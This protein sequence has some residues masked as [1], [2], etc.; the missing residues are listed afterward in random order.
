MNDEINSH[1]FKHKYYKHIPYVL[2]FPAYLIAFFIL[3]NIVNESYPNMFLSHIPLDD[4]IPFCEEF[5]IFYSLWYPLLGAMGIYLLLRDA[6]GFKKYMVYI[7][8]TFFTMIIICAVFP[9]YQ[10]MRPAITGNENVFT[11]I[12][13]R[14][15]TADTCTNVIPSAHVFGSMAVVFACFDCKS[16]KSVWWKIGASV[17]GA[18]IC[19]STV[20]V[21]QH[22]ILDVF[23]A[24]PLAFLAW[25]LVY[26]VIFKEKKAD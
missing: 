25:I 6:R 3:E 21:K 10:D 19:I 15:Y 5:V 2:I 9:N 16:L 11:F 8:V 26:K 23:V 20:F 18:L 17:I 24:I 14:I 22:S 12:M 4:M 13:K 1:P 7:G